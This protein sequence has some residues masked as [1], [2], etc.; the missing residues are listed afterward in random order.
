[1]QLLKSADLVKGL[2]ENSTEIL[3]QLQ[4]TKAL[5][6]DNALSISVRLLQI[7]GGPMSRGIQEGSRQFYIEVMEG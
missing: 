5:V 7:N 2:V 4:D 1:M 6:Q 3:K